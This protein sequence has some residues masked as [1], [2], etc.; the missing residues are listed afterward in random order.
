[1]SFI[2]LALNRQHR[3]SREIA[4]KVGEARRTGSGL[5]IRDWQIETTDE[6]SLRD[7]VD[8]IVVW[9]RDTLAACRRPYGI[10]SF[11]LTLAFDT[12]NKRP[13]SVRLDKLRPMDL[14]QETLP[15]KL[16]GFLAGEAA[17]VK[18]ASMHLTAGFFSWGDAAH[19]ALP[20]RR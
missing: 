9:C 2:F 4:R 7:A 18:A 6:S 15:E 14:Y 19:Q 1:M 16:A 17:H 5:K 13:A 8:A 3:L 10:D 12:G 11:D 20:Q